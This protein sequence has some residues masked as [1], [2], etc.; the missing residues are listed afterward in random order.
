MS[1]IRL[2]IPGTLDYRDL[3]VRVVAAACKLV[4]HRDDV[5]EDA[6]A[7]FDMHVV[8]AFGEAFNNVAIHSY[9]GRAVGPLDIE[10]EVGVGEITLRIADHGPGYDPLDVKEPDLDELPESGMGLF[11]MREFMDSVSY[12]AGA[13]NVLS[14]TK[15][16]TEKEIGGVA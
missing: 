15:K 16:L 2:T 1:L 3:A 4:A 12:Q 11:I 7:E 13:P 14:M 5:S 8:S 6:R 10:I 9:K